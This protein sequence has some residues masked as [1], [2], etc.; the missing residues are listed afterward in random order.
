MPDK[1]QEGPPERAKTPDELEKAAQDAERN[2]DFAEANA[3]N[4]EMSAAAAR[5][6]ID[7]VRAKDAE[8]QEFADA[9]YEY[10]AGAQRSDAPESGASL[11]C[12]ANCWKSPIS[13][14]IATSGGLPPWTRVVSSEVISRLPVKLT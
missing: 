9:L 13:A 7:V 2:A 5:D 14:G 3:T 11:P 1:P 10:T 6:N 12:C 8:G 4:A